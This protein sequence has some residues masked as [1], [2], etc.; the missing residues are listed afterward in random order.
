MLIVNQIGKYGLT[1]GAQSGTVML[2]KRKRGKPMKKSTLS[3]MTGCALMAA[4]MCVLCPLSIPIGPIPISLSI[5]VIL[6][7]VVML[8]TWRALVSFTVY[9]LLGAAG[10]PVFSGFQGG[11]SRLAG[12][13][14][15]YLVGFWL[16]ILIGGIIMELS[17]R[18]LL[19]TMLGMAGGVAMDYVLGTAWFMFQT[20]STVSHALAVC[21]YPFVPFDLAK[22]VIAVL[23]GDLLHRALQRARLQ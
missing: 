12:P 7:T 18:N 9:L 15:G 10:M 11:L 16:M 3:H 8:G 2:I 6:L 22:I 5:L 13:T 14:G 4:V 17:R 21:V 23:V 20:D 19:L 1:N